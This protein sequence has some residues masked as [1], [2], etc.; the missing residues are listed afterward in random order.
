[1]NM[2][3]ESLQEEGAQSGEWKQPLRG[4]NE[5]DRV[6]F[7][8]LFDYLRANGLPE[9][10]KVIYPGSAAHVAPADVFGKEN[11]V[12]IDP[13]ERAVRALSENGYTAVASRLEDYIALHER[14]LFDIAVSFNAGGIVERNYKNILKPGGFVIANNWHDT[15]N[16]LNAS[17]DFRLLGAVDRGKMGTAE[18]ANRDSAESGLGYAEYAIM[19]DGKLIFGKDKIEALRQNGFENLVETEPRATYFAWLY[20]YL[21]D[22]SGEA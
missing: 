13:E 19:P 15:A 18:L 10:P 7:N 4:T 5:R 9:A 8:A 11:T 21:P 17:P 2:E 1:M 14:D 6:E 20:Q 12:M 22:I 3:I 16:W